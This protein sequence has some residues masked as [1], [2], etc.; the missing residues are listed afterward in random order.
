MAR[1]ENK[2]CEPSYLQIA[3]VAALAIKRQPD[4][5][6]QIASKASDTHEICPLCQMIDE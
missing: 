6:T 3:G 2:V 5:G 1:E 4:C